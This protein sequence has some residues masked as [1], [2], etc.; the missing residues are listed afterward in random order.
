MSAT[1]ALSALMGPQELYELWERQQ[2][3]SAAIDFAAD[4]RD[5]ER[6]D[7][8]DREHLVWNLESFCLGEHRVTSDFT[9]LVMAHETPSEEAFLCTQQVDEA[10]HAQHFDRFYR[11][12]VG[13][14][15]G[16]P[17]GSN[18]ALARL[19]DEYLTPIGRRLLAD[20]ADRGTKVEFV[21]TYHLFVEG[22]I[23]LSGQ[24]LLTDYCERRG[25]LPGLLEGM[26]LVTQDEH[27]HIAFGVWYLR[28]EAQAPQLA[29][30]VR[31]LVPKLLRLSRDA[32]TPPEGDPAAA[33]LG[34]APGEGARFAYAGLHRRLKMIGVSLPA[35]ERLAARA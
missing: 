5:W 15:D 8:T 25:V 2:W 21:T 33:V 10:R 26:R 7:E 28:R 6:L 23:A 1:N 13:E 19:F 34:Q 4:R 24:A 12:V 18:P 20:P 16:G 32:L 30:R 35:M 27:R 22:V 3:S 11:E 29:R 31:A 9:P 14:R 17:A